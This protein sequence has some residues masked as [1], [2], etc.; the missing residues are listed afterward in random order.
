MENK[1]TYIIK[2]NQD[3][4]LFLEFINASQDYIVT[5]ENPPPPVEKKMSCKAKSR[6][7]R[8]EKPRVFTQE[9][10]SI[11]LGDLSNELRFLSG[12]FIRRDSKDISFAELSNRYRKSIQRFFSRHTIKITHQETE[13]NLIFKPL[14]SR[15]LESS[16][17]KIK[18]S[19]ELIEPK[20]TLS[21][22]IQT[23]LIDI[24]TKHTD[25]TINTFLPNHP[26]YNI[27]VSVNFS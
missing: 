12:S 18:M 26:L 15:T 16:T 20:L 5:Q 13:H 27:K 11:L 3:L 19:L 21:P 10:K 24:I 2:T 14:Y 4:L 6:P 23:K 1:N 25:S 7:K 22:D 9:R 17:H 8:K